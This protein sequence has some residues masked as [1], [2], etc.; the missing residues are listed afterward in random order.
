MIEKE[1][2]KTLE[3]YCEKATQYYK[4]KV[5][6]PYSITCSTF[7]YQESDVNTLEEA[8]KW[9][10]YVYILIGIKSTH[11][12][13]PR[14]DFREYSIEELK[15]MIDDQYDAYCRQI[16]AERRTEQKNLK[17]ISSKNDTRGKLLWYLTQTKS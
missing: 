8:I 10:L 1:D 16:E 3:E 6:S 12:F 2:C 5:S 7:F 15:K 11:G 14:F 17:K 4:D 13:R 9:D